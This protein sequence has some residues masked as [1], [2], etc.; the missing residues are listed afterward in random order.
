MFHDGDTQ[1]LYKIAV[2]SVSTVEIK[3]SDG[4]IMTKT[5]YSSPTQGALT[6]ALG[7]LIANASLCLLVYALTH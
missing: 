5:E 6:V 3:S 4:E 2:P 7:V 1:F